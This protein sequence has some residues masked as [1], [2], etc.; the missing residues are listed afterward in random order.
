MK[1]GKE[2]LFLLPCLGYVL[3][4]VALDNILQ[5]TFAE[6][7]RKYHKHTRTF[8]F[9]AV[10]YGKVIDCKETVKLNCSYLHSK[11]INI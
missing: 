9:F 6:T 8:K 2:L 4:K 10:K 3:I 7:K 5:T 11:N 1:W